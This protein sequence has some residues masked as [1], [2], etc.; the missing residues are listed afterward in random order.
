MSAD[1]KLINDSEKPVLDEIAVIEKDI[2]QGFIGNTLINP[3][4]TLKSE[5]GG[6]G[7]EIYEDILRDPEIRQA[8]QT[9]RLAVTGR[10][11]EVIPASEDS[12]DVKIAEFIEEAFLKCNFDVGRRQLLSAIVIGFKVSEIMWEYSEGSVW[13]KRFLGK[14][15]RRFTFDTKRNLKLLTLSNMIEGE[16]VPPRKFQVFSWGSENDTPFGYG[17]GASL[18]WL[19][20]FGKNSLKF[21]LIFADKFGTPTTIGKYPTGTAKAQQDV[22][23]E[24]LESIQQEAAIKIPDT[25]TIELL[26]AARTG[27]IDTY[28]KLCNYLDKKKTKLI[29]GQTLTS[30]IGDKGSYAASQ[31]HDDVRKEIVKADADELCE[32]LNAQVVRWLVDYNFPNVT[33]Y[34]QVWIRTEDET[35]LKPL[36]ERDRIIAVDIGVPVTKKYFYDT[37]GIPEPQE[38]EE[39]IVIPARPGSFFTA[40]LPTSGNDKGNQFTEGKTFTPEQQ[41][42]EELKKA[43]IDNWEERM[44]PMIEPI[45]K[46]IEDSATL[47][48]AKAKIMEAFGIMDDAKMTEML[49]RAIFM[50]DVYGRL[51]GEKNA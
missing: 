4:K 37:Y 22:L 8:M 36:A 43:S 41:E 24:A 31:T 45:K 21:W 48:E 44:S 29:L 5:S 33:K 30:D 35:D 1:D 13:I 19:D 9:R 47:D 3:D 16:E 12:R 42:I 34:P 50:A 28:E 15:S 27:S 40:G 17:L 32:A 39:V 26:E 6:K 14:E 18:Y 46:I 49:A 38:G 10:E 11:W 23:L 7:V 20:W 51:T 25:M 2:Y